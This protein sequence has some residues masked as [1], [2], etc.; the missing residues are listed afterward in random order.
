MFSGTRKLILKS[1]FTS[2]FSNHI[3]QPL[4]SNLV[5]ST[6]SAEFLFLFDPIFMFLFQP[7]A[8][9]KISFSR[10]NSI[11]EKRMSSYRIYTYCI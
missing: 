2:H 9:L 1:V 5:L 3:N 6:T 11:F 8:L 4:V 7:F 10:E